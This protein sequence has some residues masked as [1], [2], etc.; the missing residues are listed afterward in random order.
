[1]GEQFPDSPTDLIQLA[2]TLNDT[3]DKDI[4]DLLARCFDRPAFTT[5]FHMESN[6][7][8]FDRALKYTIEVLN[9]GV[10]RL[11]DGI[12][13]KVI[14]SRHNI[15]DQKLKADLAEIT[16]LV[17]KL[18]DKFTQLKN[19]KEIQPCSCTESDCSV[20][21]LTPNACDVMDKARNE[22]LDKFKRIKPD[23]DLSIY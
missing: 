19:K 21:T 8:D 20:Y 4:I 23:F 13:F 14:P 15:S 18:R 6:I 2:K 16:K 11:N 1:M 12:S 7:P 22:I 10:Q 5:P 3:N 9:T 17:V